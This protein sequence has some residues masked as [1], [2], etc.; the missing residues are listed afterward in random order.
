MGQTVR[1]CALGGALALATVAAP[2]V[3][4]AQVVD[5]WLLDGHALEQSRA[6]GACLD[7]FARNSGTGARVAG[8]RKGEGREAAGPRHSP[9]QKRERT[10]NEAAIRRD[11]GEAASWNSHTEDTAQRADD[12]QIVESGANALRYEPPPPVTDPVT[13]ALF[14][15]KQDFQ[16][17]V[18]D[19]RRD[20]G[21][22]ARTVV[23]AGSARP[24][25][26]PPTWDR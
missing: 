13:A 7:A 1:R 22:F 19:V 23:Q 14:G 17:F 26:E 4:G 5:C 16:D 11:S 25:G 3:S 10:V 21:S 9:R 24:R 2:S 15:L 20:F 6:Q 18:D 12:A 8:D